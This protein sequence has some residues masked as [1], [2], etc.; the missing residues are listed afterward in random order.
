MP[1]YDIN[2]FARHAVRDSDFETMMWYS[3][4]ILTE[5]MNVDAKEPM[6]EMIGNIV[7][8][9]SVYGFSESKIYELKL[10]SFVLIMDQ[11]HVKCARD[12]PTFMVHSLQFRDCLQALMDN[13]LIDA[14]P[15]AQLISNPSFLDKY[16]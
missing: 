10:S 1:P 16:T 3:F 12:L 7:A 4:Y 2:W 5:G 11:V 9:A 13:N 8:A 14:N 15:M 6:K